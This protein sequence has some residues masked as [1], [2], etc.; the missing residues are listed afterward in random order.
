[1]L[2]LDAIKQ[3][4]IS[5]GVYRPARAL[6]RLLT[7]QTDYK[8]HKRLL[9]LFI[10]PGDLAFDVGANIGEKTDIMLSLGARVVAFEPQPA[11]AREVRARGSRHS[12]TVVQSAVGAKIGSAELFLTTS[13]GM[14]S[15]RPDWDH[16]AARTTILA[17]VTTLDAAIREYGKP[18]FC[19]IDVEG[20]EVDVLK[21]LSTTL[22]ALSFEYH[23]HEA[24]IVRVRDCVA[25]LMNL[26]RYEF[27]LTG[28]ESGNFLLP[29]WLPPDVFLN[30]FPACAS[31]HYY[32]DIFARLSS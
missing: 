18:V 24:A 21:G 1:M 2:S 28:T 16:S 13:T 30:A 32:G 10:R 8:D 14:A 11:L 29:E 25:R 6:H 23:C 17:S 12:L 22:S 5:L 20:F 4:S 9:S 31:P 26:G 27:Q 3:L 7:D 19:K 15:L